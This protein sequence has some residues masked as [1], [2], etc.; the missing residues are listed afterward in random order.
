MRCALTSDEGTAYQWAKV[1]DVQ[2]R[3][4]QQVMG[5]S[6]AGVTGFDVHK[7]PAGLYQVQL[8]DGVR[9]T[10]QRITKQ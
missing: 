6:E 10:T 3:V 7:L 8:F 2:G 4:V 9:L 1:V 5:S